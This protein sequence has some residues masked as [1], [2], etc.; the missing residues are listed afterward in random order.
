MGSESEL[1]KVVQREI[2][3]C[4]KPLKS[5]PNKKNISDVTLTRVDNNINRS[6]TDKDNS[7][8]VGE[9]NIEKQSNEKYSL[10]KA[11][12]KSGSSEQTKQKN[13]NASLAPKGL[14]D[15]ESR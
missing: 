15:Y 4:L 7:S 13:E 3:D 9:V 12:K 10:S 6:R 2:N 1:M 8:C 14:E 11:G 5:V